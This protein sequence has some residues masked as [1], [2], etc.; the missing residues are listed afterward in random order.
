MVSDQTVLLIYQIFSM[1]AAGILLYQTFLSILHY[2]EFKSKLSVFLAILSTTSA[3]NCFFS[4]LSIHIHHEFTK[5]IFAHGIGFGST[6]GCLVYFKL[7]STYMNYKPKF[8][9]LIEFYIT[10]GIFVIIGSTVT[11]FTQEGAFL[12]QLKPFISQSIYIVASGGQVSITPYG[13]FLFSSNVIF[14]SI[15][16]FFF[17]KKI[18]EHQK[19][20]KMLIVGIL[21]NIVFMVNDIFLAFPL[22]KYSFPLLFSSYFIEILRLSYLS[23]RD[24]ARKIEALEEEIIEIGKVAELGY[25]AGNIAHDLRNPIALIKGSAHLV[26]KALK[27]GPDALDSKSPTK[28]NMLLTQKYI[29]NILSGCNRIE[30]IIQTYL[31]MMYNERGETEDLRISTLIDQ[32]VNLCS[33]RLSELG[34]DILKLDIQDFMLSGYENQLVMAFVN[35]LSNSCEAI[36]ERQEK[37]IEISSITQGNIAFVIIKDS[38]KKISDEVSKSLFK[39]GFTT[40][41]KGKGTG[42]GLAFVK[43]VL[44][45]HYGS[46]YLDSKNQNTCFIIKLSR[47]MPANNEQ[48][49]S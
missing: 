7:M 22:I 6:I 19:P 23:Q 16:S 5:L 38:G 35:L 24:S 41:S 39:K 43:K 17:L 26:Q 10:I 13:I 44:S 30:T 20:D 47:V 4:V 2:R 46:I 48:A 34:D 36:S 42:L 1:N 18:L 27:K 12:F 45:N 49:A 40:K 14:L 33:S 21:S 15:V 8:L 29:S 9:K 3:F 37:W 28:H 32:A 25:V 11:S 31:K